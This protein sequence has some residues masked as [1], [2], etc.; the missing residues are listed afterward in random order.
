LIAA[1][2][3][4][5]KDKEKAKDFLHTV[6]VFGEGKCFPINREAIY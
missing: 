4:E 2:T 1:A 5:G 6:S 3:G